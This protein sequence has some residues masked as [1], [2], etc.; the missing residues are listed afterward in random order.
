MTPERLPNNLKAALQRLAAD[1]QPIQLTMSKADAFTII[2][3]IQLA[4][5]HPAALTS[6]AIQTAIG[7]TRQMINAIAANDNDLKMLCNMGFE[8]QF[9]EPS[10]RG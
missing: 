1:P 10:K 5:R 6:P 2:G 8:R 4:S 9:D 3:T 7:I